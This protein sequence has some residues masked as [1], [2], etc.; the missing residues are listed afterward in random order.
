M[1]RIKRQ[2]VLLAAFIIVALITTALNHT[3]QLSF[4]LSSANSDPLGLGFLFRTYVISLAHRTDR[5]ADID[6]LM[7]LLD[8]PNWHYHNATYAHTPLIDHFM[9]KVQAKRAKALED[10]AEWVTLPFAWP[11][12]AVAN[13][14][15]DKP[16]YATPLPRAGAE[17]WPQDPS[18][19]NDVLNP[20]MCATNNFKLEK[21]KTDVIQW[22]HLTPERVA[23][24]HSHMSAVRRVVDDNARLKVDFSRHPNRTQ[25]HISLILEDDIDIEWDARQRMEAVLPFL[26]WNWDVLFLGWCWSQEYHYP[27]LFGYTRPSKN[28]LHPS[29]TPRCLHAYAISPAGALKLLK[30]LRH[31]QFAYGRAVDEAFEWLVESKRVNSFSLV[32]PLIIQ[33]KITKTD[34]SLEGNDLWRESLDKGV[35]CL[36][37]DPCASS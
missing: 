34:I 21:Y 25:T 23:T 31:V 35:V 8:M 30:H 17:L 7:T 10:P 20:M 4:R 11:E 28:Q 6:K 29:F 3:D 26:P 2:L 16:L 5:Q 37:T 1:P 36:R 9:R 12:D 33:R 14:T 15:S 19:N 32:P 22:R 13:Y 24:F 18:H 27:A